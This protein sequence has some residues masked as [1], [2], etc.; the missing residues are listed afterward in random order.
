MVIKQNNLKYGAS[1][2][3]KRKKIKEQ[4]GEG[5]HRI[6]TAIFTREYEDSIMCRVVASISYDGLGEAIV[7]DKIVSDRYCPSDRRSGITNYFVSEHNWKNIYKQSLIQHKGDEYFTELEPIE[8]I[9]EMVDIFG[10]TGHKFLYK[11][12]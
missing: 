11:E 12:Q 6:G 4:L 5:L 10:I 1:M 2:M 7:V 9:Y 3:N 8:D